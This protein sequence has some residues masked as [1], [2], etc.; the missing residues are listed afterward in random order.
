MMGTA[1]VLAK[2]IRDWNNDA[3]GGKRTLVVHLGVPLSLR[4]CLGA[5]AASAV[6][7]FVLFWW[8]GPFPAWARVAGTACVLGWV[9][10]TL[11]FAR[12]LL[13]GY[14]KQ[15]AVAF[16]RGFLLSYVLLNLTVVLALLPRLA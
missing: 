7:F 13:P 1:G 15:A 4:L 11:R 12:R 16:Y 5:V 10:H 14:D 9:G 8:V 6:A 3:A 2:D